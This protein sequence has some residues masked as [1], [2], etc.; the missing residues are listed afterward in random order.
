MCSSDLDHTDGIGYGYACKNFCLVS[1]TVTSARAYIILNSSISR[2]PRATRARSRPLSPRAPPVRLVRLDPF[3]RV[4]CVP[5]RV[6]V[7]VA[8]AV[9]DAPKTPARTTTVDRRPRRDARVAAGAHARENCAL[10]R[11]MRWARGR[12][13][14]RAR[15]S[16]TS[17]WEGGVF[18]ES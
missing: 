1:L 11:D 17:S 2:P 16:S 6:A 10:A 5:I 4:P 15:P 9:D 7:A 18:G 13:T 12:V 3:A 8:V 14:S